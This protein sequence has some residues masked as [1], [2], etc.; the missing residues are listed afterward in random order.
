MVFCFYENGVVYNQPKDWG[1]FSYLGLWELMTPTIKI[2]QQV[3]RISLDIF[4]QRDF[5]G[6]DWRKES[7]RTWL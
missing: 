4:S 3:V 6:G 1:F 7:S 5:T 2:L